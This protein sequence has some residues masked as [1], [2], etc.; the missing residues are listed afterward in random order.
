[1]T[2]LVCCAALSTL[3][4][5]L[6]GCGKGHRAAPTEAPPPPAAKVTAA[7]LLKEYAANAIAADAKYKGKPLQVTGKFGH[8]E[9]VPLMGYAVQVLPEDTGGEEGTAG[10]QCFILE[11]A[12]PD[13]A[14]FQPN[15]KITLE[16]MCDGQKVVGQVVLLR[17][18]VVK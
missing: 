5:T 17:C 6:A 10:I 16:G 12:Q 18:S 4:L 3:A 1:M 15:D 14:K 2:R 9:K 7:D 13:V 11:S 8:T